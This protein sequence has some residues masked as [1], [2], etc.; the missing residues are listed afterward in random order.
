MSV[1]S[2]MDVEI[3]TGPGPGQRTSADSTMRV[4]YSRPAK[5]AAP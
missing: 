2:S 1:E 5:A 4:E 3:A